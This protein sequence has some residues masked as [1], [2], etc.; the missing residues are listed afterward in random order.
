MDTPTYNAEGQ[1]VWKPQPGEYWKGGLRYAHSYG[2]VI[3]ALKDLQ[4]SQGGTL[5][6]Y[7]NNFAGIIAAI[8]DLMQYLQ[9]GTL[10]DV[11]APPDGWEIIVNLTAALTVVAEASA[12]R[13]AVV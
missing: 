4:A 5:K 13:S 2:G 8:E 10:P 6:T 9:E 1:A 3:S 11:G 12:R 7:P